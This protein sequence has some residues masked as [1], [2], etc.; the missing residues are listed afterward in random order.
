[1]LPEEEEERR[2]A[3]EEVVGTI[4]LRHLEREEE[5]LRQRPSWMLIPLLLDLKRGGMWV[6]ERV[7]LGSRGGGWALREGEKR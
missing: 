3:A 5:V 4:P 2:T 1:M 7:E 6:G